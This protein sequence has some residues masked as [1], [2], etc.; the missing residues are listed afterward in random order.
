MRGSRAAGVQPWREHSPAPDQRA[1]GRFVTAPNQV[2][3]GEAQNKARLRSSMLSRIA[4]AGVSGNSK[5]LCGVN[6]ARPSARLS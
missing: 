6:R 4:P 2:L 5:E 3:P 1:A